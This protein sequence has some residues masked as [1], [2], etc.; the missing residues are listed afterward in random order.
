[1][2]KKLLYLKIIKVFFANRHSQAARQTKTRGERL[3]N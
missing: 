2:E 3:Q 1:M